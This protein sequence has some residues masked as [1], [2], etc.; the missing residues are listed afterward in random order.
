MAEFTRAIV[1]RARQYVGDRRRT[2]RLVAR[3]PFSLSL[4]SVTK[5]LNGTRRVSSVDGHTLDLSVKSLALIVPRI[6][7]GEHHLV[8]ENRNFNLSLE[9]PDGPIQLQAS[10]VR[11]ERLD[12]HRSEQGYLIAVK[13]V[14]ISEDDRERFEEYIANLEK[15]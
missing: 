14:N 12:E 7:L 5:S 15:K 13:I 6:T 11:Y 10:P 3:L 4:V 8:G 1:A 9:L 2:K